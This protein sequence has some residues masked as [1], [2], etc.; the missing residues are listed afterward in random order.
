V[1][2]PWL[3]YLDKKIIISLQAIQATTKLRNWV[4]ASLQIKLELVGTGTCFCRMKLL[5]LNTIINAWS[6][7]WSDISRP[8]ILS[9]TCQSASFIRD[10]NFNPTVGCSPITVFI[11]FRPFQKCYGN[12]FLLTS[13]TFYYMN[14]DYHQN[15]RNQTI[16]HSLS[17][18][19]LNESFFINNSRNFDSRT[20]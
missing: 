16:F 3:Q 11:H 14:I 12:T 2:C 19:R 10:T 4:K 18:K 8:A 5:R 15:P 13:L 7:I 6:L 20:S 1:F 9:E 17:S